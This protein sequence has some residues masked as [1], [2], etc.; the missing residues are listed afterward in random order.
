MR[1][2]SLRYALGL[3]LCFLCLSGYQPPAKYIFPLDGYQDLSGTFAELRGNHFHGGLDI[4]TYRKVGIPVKAIADGYVCRIRTGPYGFGNAVYLRHP[5][6]KYSAY[7]HLQRFTP[8]IEAIHYQTQREAQSTATDSYL[9]PQRLPVR[10][11][12]IIGYSGN[13]GSS[14][15]P[16]LHFEIRDSLERPL[17]PL[18]YF[19]DKVPDSRPPELRQIA[20]QPLALNSRIEG[21]FEKLMLRPRGSQGR[22]LHTD[23]VKV[24][25]PIGVEYEAIDRLNGASN[26]CGINYARLYLDA[27]LMFQLDLEYFDFAETRGINQHVDYAYYQSSRDRLQRAYRASGNPLPFYEGGE[28]AGWLELKDDRSHRLT[29]DLI[30]A[31]GNLSRFET[32]LRRDTSALS[33]ETLDSLQMPHP[34]VEMGRDYIHLTIEQATPDLLDGLYAQSLQGYQSFL[35]PAYQEGQDLHYLIALDPYNYPVRIFDDHGKVDFNLPYVSRVMPDRNH[36]IESG[37]WQAFFSYRSLFESLYVPHWEKA[38]Q[39]GA[40]SS[41][42]HVGDPNQPTWGGFV[43][44]IKPADSLDQRGLGIA[45]WD[46]KE[47]NYVGGRISPGGRIDTGV[48]SFGTYALVQD[49][50]PPTLRNL[51]FSSGAKINAQTPL[52]LRVEDEC[53]GIRHASIRTEI[54]G[55]WVPFRY[56]FKRDVIT[57]DLSRVELSPGPHQL[58]VE[59]EDGAGNVS[60]KEY[61]LQW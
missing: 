22:Y 6:G 9:S 33:T 58:M 8:E 11:G 7:A 55:N 13:S 49:T 21:R 54:D 19:L 24:W 59:V 52:V 34:I 42:F 28:K 3:A 30:D 46:G 32:W 27:E 26:P 10:Q 16:H 61:Q 20:F 14:F 17:N 39:E 2:S 51:S 53:S 18:P 35:S 50:I 57:G 5:D 12:D 25:G 47:W 1:F 41:L 60:R 43:V 40:L 56:D 29:L 36:L 48:G 15:G 44:S 23:T 31:H 38:S 4:K 37:D 45:R